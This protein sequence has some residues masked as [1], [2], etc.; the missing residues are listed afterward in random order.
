MAELDL[1]AF[2]GQFRDEAWEN[3]NILEQGLTALEA[4]PG[5]TALLDRMLRAVHTTKGSAKIMGFAEI[6]SLA[7]EIEEVLGAIRKGS[8]AMTPEAGDILLQAGQA[9]RVLALNRI[10]GRSEPADVAGLLAAM[11]RLLGAEEP[12]AEAAPVVTVAAAAGGRPRETM[13]VDL[14]HV[15][16]LARLVGETLALQ[17]QATE[18][19]GLLEEFVQDQDEVQLAFTNLRERLLSFRD[20]FRPRQAEEVFLYTGLLENALRNLNQ[21]SIDY[22]RQHSALLERFALALEELRQESLALRMVPIG[23]LFDVFT[24]VIRRM[25]GEAGVEVALQIRGADVELDRRVLDMLRE[26]MVHLVR[27]ALAHGIEPAEERF[28]QHKP[29]RGTLLLEAAQVGRRVQVHVRDDGRGIDLEKVRRA[30]VE[31]GILDEERA[32]AADEHTL[33]DLLFRPNFSTRRQADDLS[34]RGVGLD[35]VLSTMRQLNGSVH[36][37][38][39]AGRGTTLTMDVPLTLATIRVL[40]VEAGGAILAVP[41]NATRSLVRVRA[42]EIVPVEG[43][44]TLHW[45]GASAAL[46]SLARA[47]GLP[48]QPVEGPRPAIVVGEDGHPTALLVDRL[49][50]EIEVLVRP[51]GTILGTS[52]FFSAAT[53]LGSDQVVPILDLTGL[54]AVRPAFSHAAGPLAE[55]AAGPRRVPRILLVEDA[56]T[57]RELERSILEAA[58]YEVEAAFDGLDAMQRLEQSEFQLIISDIEMPRM[59]GFEL[60]RRVRQDPRW[61]GLPVVIISAREDEE[62]RSQGLEAGAQAYIVKSRFDQG[63]LLETIARLAAGD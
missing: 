45:H 32:R 22:Q 25:A 48:E 5:D 9:I 60:T 27:N 24:G 30:A 23:T 3:L 15:D 11:R 36:V 28:R 56:I 13:R 52:P 14:E 63:N 50:D 26:P 44:P 16:Q 34:G 8:Q 58:G 21:R 19:R 51:L 17:Q 18:E 38:S 49:L 41:S 55:A 43:R 39:Q 35:V 7:H 46:L 61:A 47:L 12:A 4:Q 6:N 54:L 2:Y 59:D 53:L 57:T 42:E 37:Q 29:R 31:R 62:S 1:T 20:R 40:L 10:E 33:L